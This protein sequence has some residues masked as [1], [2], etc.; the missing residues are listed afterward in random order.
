MPS[1]EAIL[2][3]V[4]WRRRSSCGRRLAAVVLAV[5]AMTTVS[6]CDVP[7]DRSDLMGEE[8]ATETDIRATA[9]Q[10]FDAMSRNDWDEYNRL[11]CGRQRLSASA[12]PEFARKARGLE[13]VGVDVM[14]RSDTSAQVVVEFRHSDDRAGTHTEEVT[15]IREDHEWRAC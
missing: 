9:V 12:D 5:A 10:L 8:Y 2:R 7:N 14:A 3:E 1:A 6:A 11:Q 13:V 15:I 4:V